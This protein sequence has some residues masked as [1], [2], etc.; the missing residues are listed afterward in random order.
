MSYARLTEVKMDLGIDADSTADD[1]LL[2][3]YLDEA[4]KAIDT[5]TRRTF[6]AETD[7]RYY[8]RHALDD[9][10]FILEV[11]RDLLTITTLTNGDSSGTNI[12]NTEYWLVDADGGRNLGPPYH[13]IRL[14]ID[15]TYS[16]EFDTDYWVTVIGTW[17]Y[18]TTPPRDIVRACKR[19]A[20]YYYAQKDAQVFDVTAVPEAGIIQVPQ[21]IPRDVERILQPYCRQGIA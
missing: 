14:K 2:Q 15:S 11:D 12:P 8:E 13:G 19:L 17:G 5:Y 7:T 9:S 20:M 18:S 10:G 4:T 3:A 1:V 6:E 21:G 16:W